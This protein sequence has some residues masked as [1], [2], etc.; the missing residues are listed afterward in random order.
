MRAVII[1][2]FFFDSKAVRH[3]FSTT[4][5]LVGLFLWID[6]RT[7]GLTAKTVRNRDTVFNRVANL[8]DSQVLLARSRTVKLNR[9]YCNY[10]IFQSSVSCFLLKQNKKN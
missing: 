5:P 6:T 3:H 1:F 2:L 4:K 8:L 9:F 7:T 10:K